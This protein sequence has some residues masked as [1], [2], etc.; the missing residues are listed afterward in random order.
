MTMCSMAVQLDQSSE[1]CAQYK[2]GAPTTN[3]NED[4]W[5]EMSNGQKTYTQAPQFNCHVGNFQADLKNNLNKIF[6]KH[7]KHIDVIKWKAHRPTSDY[8]D[9][10]FNITFQP[11][12]LIPT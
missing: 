7:V 11:I 12:M 1:D 9:I 4:I 5:N 10:L 2:L 6:I 8:L 3:G